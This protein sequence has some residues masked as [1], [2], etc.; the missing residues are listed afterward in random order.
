MGLQMEGFV[1]M[2]ILMGVV[3][4]AS[5]LAARQAQSILVMGLIL[6]LIAER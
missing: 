3:S 4:Q 2:L 6:I 5:V 1:A